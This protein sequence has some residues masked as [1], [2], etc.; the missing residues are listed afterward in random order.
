[1]SELRAH[2]FAYVIFGAACVVSVVA[3]IVAVGP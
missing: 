1:M 3:L 2:W